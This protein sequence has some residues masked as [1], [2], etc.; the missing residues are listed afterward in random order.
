L[1]HQQEAIYEH[2]KPDLSYSPSVIVHSLELLFELS[3]QQR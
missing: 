3:A 1:I 2:N